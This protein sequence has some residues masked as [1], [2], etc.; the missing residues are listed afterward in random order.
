MAPQ[1]TMIPNVQAEEVVSM[2]RAEEE[3]QRSMKEQKE[4]FPWKTKEQT[5]EKTKLMVSNTVSISFW[6]VVLD[7]T[8]LE[9]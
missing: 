6:Q 7:E 1:G 9:E 5:K 2:K 3:S 4:V 8:L